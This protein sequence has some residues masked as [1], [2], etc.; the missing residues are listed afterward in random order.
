MTAS[1][2]PLAANTGATSTSNATSESG[3]G[4]DASSSPV[5]SSPITTSDKAGAAILTII[6][7]VAAATACMFMILD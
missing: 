3:Q 2:A 7:C 4:V 5:E 6:V 1:M